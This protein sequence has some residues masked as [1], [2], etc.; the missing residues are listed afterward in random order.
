MSENKNTE[1]NAEN[2]EEKSSSTPEELISKMEEGQHESSEENSSHEEELHHETDESLLSKLGFN[3]KDKHKKEKELKEKLDE[4][5]D[6]YLRLAAEFDNFK[7]RNAKDKIE[8]VKLAGQEIMTA[9]LPVLDDFGR[10]LKQI[11][12]SGDKEALQKGVELIY[13]KMKNTLEV[14]G[15]KEMESIGKDFNVEEHEAITEVPA[16]TDEQK[17]KVLD[18]IEKGFYLNDKIIR[19]AKVV[20][21]K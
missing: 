20:V 13:Q 18:E 8:F 16:P 6:K 17:G 11:E 12:T 19:F 10:A 15:L 4:A 7:K 3:K 21:G 5:N 14:R 2:N 9:M 1:M